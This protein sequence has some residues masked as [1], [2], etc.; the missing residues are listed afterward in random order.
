[1]SNEKSNH[2]NA[3]VKW[4]ILILFIGT[5]TFSGFAGWQRYSL[6]KYENRLNETIE[7]KDSAIKQFEIYEKVQEK[8]TAQQIFEKAEDYRINWSEPLE[9]IFALEN[10]NIRFES[11]SIT[12]DQKISIS[13]TAQ[14][15]ESIALLIETIDKDPRYQQP[16]VGGFSEQT[17]ET[18][19][20]YSFNIT[21][22]YTEKL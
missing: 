9:N 17:S 3:A 22:I 20:N 11:L 18:R 21:F 14:N 6:K 10:K 19:N 2:Q 16:F 7:K 8:H 4:V 15:Y 1:M 12:K 5:I 13:A